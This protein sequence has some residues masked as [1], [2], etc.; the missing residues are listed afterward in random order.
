MSGGLFIKSLHVY[1]MLICWVAL[2]PQPPKQ[3]GSWLV[4]TYVFQ[5]NGLQTFTPP[6]W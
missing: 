3:L 5:T 1:M 6:G 4:R 2:I